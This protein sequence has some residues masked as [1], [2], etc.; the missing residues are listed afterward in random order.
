MGRVWVVGN[1]SLDV[2]LGGIEDF[3]GWGVEVL[4]PGYVMRPGG[5]ATNAALALTGLGVSNFL[6]GVVGD[7]F[8]GKEVIGKLEKQGVNLSFL[9][10]ARNVATGLSV[11]VTHS[12]TLERT[13]LTDL[14]A[15]A[16]LTLGHLENLFSEVRNGDF[17]L[18]CG[19]FLSPGIRKGKLLVEILEEFRSK[20]VKLLLDTGWPTEGFTEE[21]REEIF[22]LLP[23]FD[24]F[25]PNRVE[26]QALTGEN[27]S[28]IFK[29]F[30]GVLIV[31]KGKEGS[32]ALTASESLIREAVPFEAKD[33]IGAG[34]YF[35]A[36]F[37]FALLSGENLN[38]ALHIA[39]L[40]AGYNISTDSARENLIT[41]EKLEEMLSSYS[42]R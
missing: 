35:N 9:D 29:N 20:G 1:I 19:Y 15:Q 10:V 22:S 3:P 17:M 8:A 26:L 18:L 23:A 25:L 39:N 27:L 37:I 4:I 12:V 31:K 40:V 41:R 38:R 16:V 5:A 2:V 7:D 13:F 36:G 32:Q 6:V 34:D 33:T 30:S 11:A 14:G 21:V 24:Y 42:D 28:R